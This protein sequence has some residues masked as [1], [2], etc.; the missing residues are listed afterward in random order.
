MNYELFGPCMKRFAPCIQHFVAQTDWNLRSPLLITEMK[1]EVAWRERCSSQVI[2]LFWLH[3]ML[4]SSPGCCV[5]YFLENVMLVL[6]GSRHLKLYMKQ[7]RMTW[8]NLLKMAC[9]LYCCLIM[10]CSLSDCAYWML[11]WLQRAGMFSRWHQTSN[12]RTILR[13]QRWLAM[14]TMLGCMCDGPCAFKL[15][16]FFSAWGKCHRLC[17]GFVNTRVCQYCSSEARASIQTHVLVPACSSQHA[18]WN[19]T[20]FELQGLVE[21]I[22]DRTLEE[23]PSWWLALRC[24]FTSSYSSSTWNG[25][26]CGT[27]WSNAHLASRHGAA[28]L[29]INCCNLVSFYVCLALSHCMAS[30]PSLYMCVSGCGALRYCFHVIGNGLEER[31]RKLKCLQPLL[32]SCRGKNSYQVA[33]GEYHVFLLG[34]IHLNFWDVKAQTNVQFHRIWPFEDVQDAFASCMQFLWW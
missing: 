20:D 11:F 19:R 22:I 17:T 4:V 15:F 6:M 29:C 24:Q 21:C 13:C 7:L 18:V 28:F 27:T 14:A 1:A 12:L 25:S 8:W 23:Q 26:Y 3:Q 5:R 9:R 31:R 32:I 30:I 2:S 33:I 16:F 10:T 34:S